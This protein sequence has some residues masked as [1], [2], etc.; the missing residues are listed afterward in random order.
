MNVF[1]TRSK[2]TRPT[3]TS[4]LSNS[5]TRKRSE[6]GSPRDERLTRFTETKHLGGRAYGE[7]DGADGR[8][9]LRC[10]RKVMGQAVCCLISSLG[11]SGCIQARV[12]QRWFSQ[13]EHSPTWPR[14]GLHDGDDDENFRYIRSISVMKDWV[15]ANIRSR[16]TTRWR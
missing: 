7:G 14:S 2:A 15:D 3:V 13:Q 1:E 10:A 9:R 6:N 5:Q 4:L 12:S 16:L 8:T 11:L